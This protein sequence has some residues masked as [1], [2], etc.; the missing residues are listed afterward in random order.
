MDIELVVHYAQWLLVILASYLLFTIARLSRQEARCKALSQGVSHPPL[1]RY[2]TP[3]RIEGIAQLQKFTASQ[4]LELRLKGLDPVKLRRKDWLFNGTCHYFWGA[5]Q[6][7]TNQMRCPEQL[8]DLFEF[9]LR[10][11]LGVDVLDTPHVV[12]QLQQGPVL[13]FEQQAAD[14][15]RVAAEHWLTSKRVPEN[16]SLFS[17]INEWSMA[18]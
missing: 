8:H 1:E 10:R 6:T 16:A 4:L 15:G 18:V 13:D 5:C 14:F 7:I 3:A 9:V 17:S 12:R 2:P 11:N